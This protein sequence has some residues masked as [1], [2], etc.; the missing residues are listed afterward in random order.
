MSRGGREELSVVYCSSTYIYD[1][2][3]MHLPHTAVEC[4]YMYM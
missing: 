1:V 4:R 2:I 3:E